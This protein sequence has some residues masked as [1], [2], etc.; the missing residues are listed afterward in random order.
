[1]YTVTVPCDVSPVKWNVYSLLGSFAS[2]P[3]SGPPNSVIS[4]TMFN[5]LPAVEM[6]VVLL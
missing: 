4:P 6:N 1:M 3:A 5:W 2:R